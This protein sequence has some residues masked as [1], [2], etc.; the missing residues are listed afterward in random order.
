[1]AAQST[2][3]ST[4][5]V[6]MPDRLLT[7]GELARRAGIASS[8]LRYYEELAL[9]PPPARVSGQRRYPES[10]VGLVGI[11]LLLRDA[12]FSLAEQKALLAARAAAPDE[13]PGPPPPR[14]APPPPPPPH[15]PRAPP[16]P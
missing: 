8:A 6:K 2:P 9:L 5:E 15:S 14:P 16:R 1:M 4:L 3:S 7:I 12:G 13:W 11:I 10:A